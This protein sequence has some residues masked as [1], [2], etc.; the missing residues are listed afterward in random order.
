MGNKD[1]KKQV[2]QEI[3]NSYESLY[4]VAYVYMQNKEAAMDVVQDVV[5]KALSNVN[6]IQSEEAIR[7]W[8]Y[9]TTIN[10]ALDALRKRIREVPIN[11]GVGEDAEAPEPTFSIEMREMLDS[12]DEKEKTVMILRFFEDRKLAEIAEI[13][14][15]NVSTVKS[16]L[17]RTLKRLKIELEDG[18][19][20]D[21]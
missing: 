19:E 5:V 17:Y 20:L 8:L 21:A 1:L 9:R 15:E 13:M 7:S 2:E 10:T 16:I 11:E 4:R 12:L 6:K 14:D 18:G 3:L